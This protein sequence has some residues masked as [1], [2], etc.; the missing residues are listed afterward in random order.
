MAPFLKNNLG[1]RKGSDTIQNDTDG[2][3]ILPSNQP[4]GVNYTQD[5]HMVF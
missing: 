1:L 5:T 3:D 2:A 4:K